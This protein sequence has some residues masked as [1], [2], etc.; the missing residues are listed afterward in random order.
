MPYILGVG[1]RTTAIGM[2]VT[3]VTLYGLSLVMEL[4][5]RVFKQSDRQVDR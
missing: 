2:G 1:L 3:F 4:M 5:A